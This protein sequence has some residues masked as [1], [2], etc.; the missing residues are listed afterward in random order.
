V[1]RTQIESGVPI[2]DI[3]ASWADDEAAFRKL[4]QPYL[5]Y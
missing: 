5:M 3:A 4:R 1:L 2:G